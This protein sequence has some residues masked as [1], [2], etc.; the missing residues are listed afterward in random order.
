MDMLCEKYQCTGCGA[1]SSVCPH[2]A[3][4][5]IPGHLGA[6]CAEIDADRCVD[7]GS[8]SAVCPVVSPVELRE[9]CSA[10]AAYSVSSD[11]RASSASGGAAS[12]L[13]RNVISAGGVVYGCVQKN[14]PEISHVRV[15]SLND[16]ELLKGSK[17]V[18][19][20]ASA[21]YGMVRR[22]LEDGREVLFVG[23]PCQVAGLKNIMNGR[24]ADRLITADLC[25]HG[26]P[27]V[28]LLRNHLDFIG[29]ARN[30][31]RVTFRKKDGDRIHYVMCV[32]DSSGRVVYDRPSGRDYYMTGFLS[33]M[34][35]RENFFSCRY[36][37]PLRCSDLTL[38][39]FWSIGTVSDP[40]M[41]VSRGLSAVLINTD[42]GR[43]LFDRIADQMV[44]QERP[45]AEALR[46]AR[47]IG[48]EVKPD[49]YDKFV[50][51]YDRYGYSASCRRY[52]PA[53]QLEIFFDK[54][55]DIYYKW[56][57]RQFLRKILK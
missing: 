43:T 22:D 30:A 1:C 4:S 55:R 42:K 50:E 45:L 10:Y 29:A 53:F 20:D 44:C 16:V 52:L 3:I 26:T 21:V 48:P 51:H 40:Q 9:P 57:L 35:L 19:S 23:T 11:D 46:N 31:D 7:C 12:A 41:K 18:Q 6:L 24:L 2:G 17:Y 47:F 27:P 13:A 5:M 36:A 32:T 33:G 39:D 56:P 14:G 38:S 37:S 25:C 54:L 8:C 15:D 28:S 49:A 34:F